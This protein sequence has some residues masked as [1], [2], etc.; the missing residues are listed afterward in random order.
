[1]VPFST[2]ILAAGKGT[3]MKSALP[4]VLF[5]ACGKSLLSY[6][7]NATVDATKHYVVIGHC[8][9][10]VLKELKGLKVNFL[11]VWQREQKG[12]GHA[13]QMALPV[14]EEELLLI[15]NG[16]GPTL[17]RETV[18]SIL[19]E[20]KKRRADITLGCMTLE[21]PF[22]YGRVVL[23]PKNT[24][25]RIVEEKDATDKERKIHVVNGG[26][27]VLSR[28][29][30]RKV[31]PLLK[32]S[33]VTGEI[34]LTDILAI[35]AKLKKKMLSFSMEQEDLLG[36]NDMAQLVQVEKIIRERM[37]RE[38]MKSGTRVQ[39]PYTVFTDFGVV[40]EPGATLG[41]N[42]ILTG[43][44]VIGAG[45]II[46]AGSVLKNAK[47]A[48]NVE[49]RAYS[50]IEES[51][52]GSGTQ[53]GPFARIRPGSEIGEE[54]KIG[55]FVEVKKTRFGKGSKASHLAY[56]GDADLGDDVNVGCGYITCNYDGVNKHK[57]KIGDRVF[58]GA[59]VQT[60]APIEI[61]SDSY[62]A[63]GSTIS[64][65]VPSGALAISRVKQEN[66]EGYAE[67]L[68]SRFQ[69]AKKKD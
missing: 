12:T 41:P 58:L 38:W 60:I 3:R 35:G 29:F 5:P 53:I 27:Y 9:E 30:L 8:G 28:S 15:V 67:R 20:H 46:E 26:I 52:I 49:V 13:V 65:N 18:H 55:N 11:E 66:K 4:K 56:L 16:D 25:K 17:R 7:I 45:S 33:K 57:T 6:V 61:G 64:R 39:D 47:I 14:L 23:G 68:K 19:A 69:A 43:S 48:P 22:G 42:V 32:P 36:V 34:Y 24:I 31:L 2:V 54:C 44:T 40:V 63:T 21:N 51:S 10:E 59:D 37:V 62:I 50:Y 1:M